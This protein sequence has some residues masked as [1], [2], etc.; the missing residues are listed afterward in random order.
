VKCLCWWDGSLTSVTYFT[1]FTVYYFTR[2]NHTIIFSWDTNIYIVKKTQPIR[3]LI[4]N[5]EDIICSPKLSQQSLP[6]NSFS[7]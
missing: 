6:H 2:D 7:T 1:N 3:G 5:E 4:T